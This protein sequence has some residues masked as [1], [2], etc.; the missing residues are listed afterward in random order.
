MWPTWLFPEY[1]YTV[2]SETK[3]D[4]MYISIESNDKKSNLAEQI[5][6]LKKSLPDN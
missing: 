2:C 5:N 6:F 3:E 1:F 4:I